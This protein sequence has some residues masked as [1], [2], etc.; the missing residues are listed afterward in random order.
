M[1]QNHLT[2]KEIIFAYAEKTK[3]G[4]N[5]LQNASYYAMSLAG[6]VGEYCNFVKKR[7]RGDLNLPLTEKQREKIIK[8]IGNVSDLEI[9]K[10]RNKEYIEEEARELADA[11]LYI[12]LICQKEGID[13]DKY[14]R[15]KFNLF[16]DK[17]KSNVKL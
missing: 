16:S 17:Q 2:F 12:L 14:I 5:D 4:N 6:E 13:I 15:E 11:I 3:E 1:E 7:L 9:L 8:I 10:F